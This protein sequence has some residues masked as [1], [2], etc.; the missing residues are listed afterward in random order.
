MWSAAGGVGLTE[1][2]GK[3]WAG[4]DLVDTSQ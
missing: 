2:P 4:P 3:Y 1:P